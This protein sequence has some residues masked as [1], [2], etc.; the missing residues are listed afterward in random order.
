MWEALKRL[1]RIRDEA[2]SKR[3]VLSQMSIYIVSDEKAEERLRKLREFY[4]VR[5]QVIN[6]YKDFEGRRLTPEQALEAL[7]DYMNLLNQ[8]L[9]TVAVPYLRALDDKNASVI[10]RAWSRLNGY[11]FDI[12]D[13]FLNWFKRVT[14]LEERIREGRA[15]EDE[16]KAYNALKPRLPKDVIVSSFLSFVIRE[17][18]PRAEAIMRVSWSSADVTPSWVG[19]IQPQI[20]QVPGAPP[21]REDAAAPTSEETRLRRRGTQ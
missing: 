19:A 14:V 11:F 16:V 18:L 17:Y 7:L 20:I 13:T 2:A 21:P 3:E 4:D 9:D 1:L 8:Y 15:T 10:V 12:G 5:N 6:L